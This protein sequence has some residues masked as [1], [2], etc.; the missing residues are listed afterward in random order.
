MT[1]SPPNILLILADQ[2]RFDCLG[3][4]GHPAVRT[5]NL[6]RLAERGVLF[7]SAYAP[8]TP[9]GPARAS[10][11]TGRYPDAHGLCSG[12]NHL[13]PPDRPVLPEMLQQAGYETALV[14]KL[15]LKPLTRRYGFAHC[16]R[17]DSFCTLY[18]PEEVTD[19]AYVR[20]L[21]E[22]LGDDASADL[23]ARFDADE[24]AFASDELRFLLGSDVVDEAHHPTTWTAREIA[25]LLRELPGTRAGRPF[26]VNCSF[27][28]PHQPYR[29]PGRWGT[30]FDPADVPLPA[31]FHATMED[32]PILRHSWLSDHPARRR[33]RG[34]TED[35]Y[36]TLLAAYYG[37]IAMIDHYVGEVLGAL[38][39]RGL[40][41]DT[42]VIFSADH[43]DYAG[44]FGCFYKSIPYEGSA[45]VPLIVHD[46]C[47][48]QPGRREERAVSTI[49]LFATLLQCGGA[50]V[51]GDSE[52]RDLRDL[53][54]RPNAPW[55]DSA[56]HKEGPR[57]LLVRGKWKLLRG[58]GEGGEMAYELYD[59]TEVPLDGTN[60]ID[61]PRCA[62]IAFALRAELDAWHE[63]QDAAA[64]RMK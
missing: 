37:G 5:P 7:T 9:C 41:D 28:G 21:R 39:E 51:P 35:T 45:H 10:V 62:D 3:A 50:A 6:D 29:C 12:H 16:L 11:F 23:V 47:N 30:L 27:F 32:K 36:R 24:A 26:L 43:G 63:R 34:W 42:L 31:D 18:D 38:D 58:P 48:P 17:S 53:L 52:S 44:Q 57:S 22:T 49:D 56:L 59:R 54:L 2:W 64:G 4:L 8:T 55:D 14:G 25:R 60:R 46:P 20:W 13:D 33:E 40:W 61:D 15:H 19:S 1:T